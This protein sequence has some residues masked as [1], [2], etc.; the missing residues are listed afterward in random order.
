M[1]HISEVWER[2]DA[3][4]HAGAEGLLRGDPDL[5]DSDAGQMALGY[6]L[7]F[8]QRCPEASAVYAGLRKRHA[9]EPWEH[10]AVHQLGMVARMHGDWDSAR[11]LFEEEA[12]MIGAAGLGSHEHSVNAYEQGYVALK[13]GQLEQASTHLNRGLTLAQ[14]GD[15]PVA[16]ACAHRG[17]GELALAHGDAHEAHRQFGL[18]LACFEEAE[19]EPEAAEM[20]ARLLELGSPA[21]A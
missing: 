7:A 8:T 15:D 17:L 10:I 1:S 3:G 14:Q 12:Q 2:I 19:D 20:R 18:A 6:T 4:D 16:V 13:M 11:A 21:T 9:G 5:L